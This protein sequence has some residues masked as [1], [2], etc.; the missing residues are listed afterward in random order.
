MKENLCYWYLELCFGLFIG[1]DVVDEKRF[2]VNKWF[3]FSFREYVWV[4]CNFYLRGNLLFWVF[5]VVDI[6]FF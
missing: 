5:I 3:N 4:I 2:G 1:I 6:F